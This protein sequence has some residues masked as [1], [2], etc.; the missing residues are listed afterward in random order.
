MT[1][2]TQIPVSKEL[3]KAFKTEA[4]E[5]GITMIELMDEVYELYLRNIGK[6]RR[7]R[8]EEEQQELFANPERDSRRN[9]EK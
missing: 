2:R 1:E 6:E 4:A 5:R 7:K 8:P 9:G 3:K